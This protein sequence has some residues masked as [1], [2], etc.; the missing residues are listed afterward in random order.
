MLALLVLLRLDVGAVAAVVDAVA[1][2]VAVARAGVPT[3]LLR[4]PPPPNRR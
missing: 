3:I 2:D 4:S 1:A